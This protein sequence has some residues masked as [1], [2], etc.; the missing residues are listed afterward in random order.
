M[1]NFFST[2][3]LFFLVLCYF[4]TILA[5]KNIKLDS[6]HQAYKEAKQDTVRIKILSEIAF[7]YSYA[8]PD[9]SI[10]LAENII[11]ESKE[12]DF[13]KG[14]AAAYHVKGHAYYV[15]SNMLES[16]KYYKKSIE[17]STEIEDK[18]KSRTKS[19]KFS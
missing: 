19:R 4:P 11:E 16:I 14:V 1:S 13:K 9:T 8:N 5:Q 3:L 18:N 7:V 6:L 15:Q 10:I 2:S 12:L 17:I